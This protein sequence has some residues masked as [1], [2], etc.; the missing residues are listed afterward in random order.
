M[1]FREIHLIGIRSGEITLAFHRWQKASVKTG[2]LLH[3]VV[4][5]IAICIA[6]LTGFERDRLKLNIRKLKNS[7]STISPSVGYELSP[8][9]KSFMEMIMYKST[10]IKLKEP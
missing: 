9:G 10:A 2:S 3:T 1:L 5:L 4:S 8:V 6:K 7:G